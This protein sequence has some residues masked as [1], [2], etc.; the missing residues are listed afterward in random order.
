MRQLGNRLAGAYTSMGEKGMKNFSSPIR[1]ILF[2]GACLFGLLT[3]IPSH[4]AEGL[5]KLR[6]AYAAITAAF[7]IPWVAKEAGIFQ[8]HG[9]DVELVYIASGSRAVQTLIGG[10]VDVAAFG[11]PAAIDAK[12]AGADTVYVS[13]PV[14][15]VI[16]FT[17][18]A[19]QIQR[20]EDLRGKSIGATRIGTVTDFFT[21]Y[22]LRQNGLVP[23]RD[24]MIRQTGGLPETLA[25]LKAGQIHAGTFGFP[26]VLH[27]RAAG[28]RVLVDYSKQ[29]FRY[30]L[31]AVAV[32][33]SMLRSQESAIRRFLEAS[34]EGIHRFRTDPAFAMNVIG[35][36]T[37]TADRTILEETQK[38]YASAFE[39][40]PYPD[41]EDLKLAISQVAEGNPRARGAEPRDFIEPRL[42]REIEASG[43]VK[44]LYGEQVK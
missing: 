1:R 6:V 39:P 40:V 25:A 24:V 36:Y 23:D 42:I 11:G 22:F 2:T 10:G 19:P 9:L 28:F 37:Q 34:I 30:P 43:F 16:V 31:S 4:A 27:A 15:K 44:K 33:Q 12:L 14:N 26:A 13:I 32:T 35:K 29:G 8:R 20:V 41:P 7:S 5:Q 17:V 3:T 21:R 38:V 18:V